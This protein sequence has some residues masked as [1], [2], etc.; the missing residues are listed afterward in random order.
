MGLGYLPE[1]TA[2]FMS[3]MTA[4]ADIWARLAPRLVSWSN[5]C[6]CD[7]LEHGEPAVEVNEAGR[8]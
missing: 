3:K 4:I 5:G 6:Y 8:A 2:C 1:A 7:L